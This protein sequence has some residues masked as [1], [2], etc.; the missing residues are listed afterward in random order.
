[1]AVVGFGMP[2]KL[3]FIVAAAAGIVLGLAVERWR[4]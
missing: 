3:G 2:Y 1:V 4:A